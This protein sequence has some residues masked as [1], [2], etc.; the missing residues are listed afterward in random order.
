MSQLLQD[1]RLS[2]RRMRREPVFT[3]VV[4]ATLA[5]A[6]GATTAVFSLVYQVLLKPLPYPEPQELL[7][8]YQSTP[9]R[10]RGGVAYSYLQAWR[11]RSDA[12]QGIEGVTAV[13]YTLTGPGAAQ[14]VRAGLATPGLLPLLG[15]RPERGQ[16]FGPESQV[17]G[18]DRGVLLSHA[19]WWRHFAGR[20]DVVGQ[21]VTL[22]GTPHV[23][24]G[25]LP[26]SFRFW[27]GV[28]LWMPLAPATAAPGQVPEELYVRGVGRLR[29]GVPLERARA[30]L[31]ERSRAWAATVG[32]GEAVPGVRLVPLHE[33]VVETSREQ[34][35]LLAGVM[36]LVLCVA[37]A[38]VANLL[39]ARAS[40][41]EREVAVR[42][43]L[44][45]DRG[46]LVRQFLVESAVLAVL[47]GAV[48]LLL[49]LWG[50]DLLRVFVPGEVVSPEEIRLEPHVLAIA[51]G[52]SL[53]T[54][55][56]FG[57]VPALRA[58]RAEAKGALGGLRGGRGATGPVRARAVLVVA[59]VA[60]ALVPLVG[61]GLMLRTLHALHSVAPG[62]EPHGVSAMDL[63]FPREAYGEDDTRRRLVSA[64]LLARVR[65]LPSVQS[66]GLAST[67]PLWNRNGFSAVLLPGET[68]REA[69]AREPVN[70]RAV[71]DGYFATLRIPLKEGRDVRAS[72]GAG[73]APVMVVNEAFVKRFLPKGP[74][75][76]QRARLTLDGE[77]FREV[78]GV[79]GD[80]HHASLAEEPRAEVYLPMDQFE[81]LHMVIAVRATRSAQ[82]LVP[83][84][85]EQLRAVDPG[86]PLM[87]VRDLEDVVSESLGRT[88]VM[89]G[90]LTAMAVLALTLAGV[91]LYGVLAY[92]VS[93]RT[94]ELGIRMALGAT[95]R[96][97]LW[98]VVGQGLRLAAVGVGVGLV[99]AAVLARGL[100]GMLYGVGTLDALTFGGVPLL[101]GVVALVASWLPARR[102]LRVTPAIALRADE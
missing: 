62:F 99:G 12:F 85:R 80:V 38:N 82:A 90:L 8:L 32:G 59:Q 81:G 34:L 30:E 39:L 58:S 43:A 97:V 88:Q 36:V 45:A 91:G 40:A 33:Q 13:D 5:L 10:E 66:A 86:L 24:Q 46:R 16:A 1:V 37:C 19:F 56:L 74:S 3:G 15:V 100:A 22:D 92:T 69:D 95:D 67:L 98:L 94:R 76:G 11:E 55:I 18:R 26:A 75:L 71:S 78:V 57:L 72:D 50:M 89:G 48:G 101:L 14:R 28:E 73:S 77:P 21:T 84:L 63:S 31:E 4:V 102:A 7:R 79:V 65:A 54:S 47:G 96:Q 27:P 49:A 83:A 23:V 41:R 6:I 70:F 52:L 87:Q 68:E 42:A 64:E 9:Q 17:P 29:P 25:V 44:G 61:A 35:W 20:A 2:L 60:L 53:T 93:Q 51:A